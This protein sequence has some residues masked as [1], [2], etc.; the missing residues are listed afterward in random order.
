[1]WKDF[2]FYPEQ[3]STI[4][5][6]VDL[7]YFFLVAVSA[8]F[9]LLITVLVVVFATKYRASRPHPSS[10]HIVGSNKLGGDGGDRS[11]VHLRQAA[12]VVADLLDR[13]RVLLHE[14]PRLL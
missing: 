7:L 10:T 11:I 8:F 6:P 12:D 2:P 4:A 1:M 9:A 13:P 3:A 14:L 5:Q